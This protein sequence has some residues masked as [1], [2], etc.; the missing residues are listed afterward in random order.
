MTTIPTD[1]LEAMGFEGL[2]VNLEISLF[3]YGGAYCPALNLAL[4]VMPDMKDPKM[5]FTWITP[6]EITLEI[7]RGGK[8]FH[9]FTDDS[10]P[11]PDGMQAIQSLMLWNG[12]F[13]SDYPLW[14]SLSQWTEKEFDTVLHTMAGAKKGGE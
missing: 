12:G 1:E 4:L 5:A 14:R 9:S 11:V 10:L 8:D 2:D 13:H 6:D 3:E 7:E